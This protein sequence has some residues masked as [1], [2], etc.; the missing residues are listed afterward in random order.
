MIN[1][2][3]EIKYDDVCDDDAC[4]NRQE[5]PNVINDSDDQRDSSYHFDSTNPWS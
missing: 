4:D 2:T 1:D 3:Y 5:H